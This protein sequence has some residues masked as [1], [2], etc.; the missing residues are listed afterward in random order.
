MFLDNDDPLNPAGG[1]LSVGAGGGA[2][3]SGQARKNPAAAGKGSGAWTNLDQYINAN[4]G[5]GDQFAGNF[6]QKTSADR[7]ALESGWDEL[8]TDS[9]GKITSNLNTSMGALN[10]AE[11]GLD[12]PSEGNTPS[13]NIAFSNWDAPNTGWV[14]DATTAKNA[15]NTKM[16]GYKDNPTSL[17]RDTEASD[18]TAGGS[19][20]NDYL[21]SG[22]GA[23]GRIASAAGG[24]NITRDFDPDVAEIN[25][26][27]DA[28]LESITGGRARLLSSAKVKQG[29]YKGKATAA[30]I[31]AEN[32]DIA[33]ISVPKLVPYVDPHPK[34][35]REALQIMLDLGGNS[36]IQADKILADRK[37][38]RELSESNKLKYDIAM[39]NYNRSVGN[40]RNKITS[41]SADPEN[42][43]DYAA[44]EK[45]INQYG[46]VQ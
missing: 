16:T 45:L 24:A 38:A 4:A 2:A 46:G 6:E 17:L 8:K 40:S 10:T 7:G 30:E 32:A 12:N 26:A 36:K 22:S 15:W 39:E 33:G 21:F 31:A 5:M 27:N 14:N 19:S 9:L 37:A 35:T 34:F 13:W 18:L 44:L 1:A 28:A 43:A 11:S 25:S 3:V 20:L 23:S 29:E 41:A 42:W